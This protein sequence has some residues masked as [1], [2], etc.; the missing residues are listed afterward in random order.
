MT[1]HEWPQPEWKLG[2]NRAGGS[3]RMTSRENPPTSSHR[4]AEW[5]KPLG[6]RLALAAWLAM[7]P[8]VCVASPPAQ[9]PLGRPVVVLGLPQC[10][11]LA[12][13]RQPVLAARRASLA[14]AE[15]AARALHA[16]KVPAFLVPE[17]PIRRD[18]ASLGV[19]AAA[20]ALAQAERDA[21]YAVLRTY[22]TVLYARDQE[23]VARRVVARLTAVRDAAGV[24][25]KAGEGDVTTDD[26]QRAAIYVDVA[27]AKRVEASVGV[28]RAMAA[29]REALGI[30]G[31][32]FAIPRAPLPQPTTRPCRE[33]VIA[34]ALERRGEI[35][36]AGVVA[37]ITNLEVDAQA[38]GSGPRMETFARGA[39]LHSTPLPADSR[40]TQYQPGALA[41]EMPDLLVGT[42]AERVLR[43]RSLGARALAVV[44]KTRGLIVLEAEDAYLRWEEAAQKIERT[45]RAVQSAQ[46]LAEALDEYLR[47]GQ[48]VRVDEVTT[49][50]I[51][52][53]QVQSNYLEALHQQLLALAD[54][55]R[56][57]AGGF[58]SGIVTALTQPNPAKP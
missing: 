26:V 43:A 46:K 38:V 35:I 51:L 58:C 5:T 32:P 17:L 55:E 24:M 50:H 52:A 53:A 11:A 49:A 13:E 30:G 19:T 6:R 45:R 33:Q 9:A 34:L 1:L 20:A 22:L 15:D 39:D 8:T 14:S 12:R 18:Q 4:S 21:D 23:E 7:L 48:K 2:G 41:P 42:K 40:G 47:T 3:A 27:D 25:A 37:D 28:D 57:T 54:L 56:I 10:L 36:Q 31:E 29:L 44:D 16:L